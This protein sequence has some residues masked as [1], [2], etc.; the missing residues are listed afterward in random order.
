[1]IAFELVTLT[2]TK[3]GG[4]VYEV[5]LPT[6]DGTIAVFLNHMPL[7]SLASPGV[8]SIRR[9]Q[10]H[11]DDFMEHYA[12]NGGVI[13][14]LDNKV[15]VLVDEADAASEISEAEAKKALEQAKKLRSE[16]KDQVS[17]DKAQ[18]MIDR[19]NIRLRVNELKK[20]RK[21]RVK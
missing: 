13:E 16:A 15:R 2:G 5:L 20:R 14:V 19:S 21:N 4:D 9:K 3:F 1:M 8:I 6:P 11:P 18:A 17:L 10:E 7:V 12:T